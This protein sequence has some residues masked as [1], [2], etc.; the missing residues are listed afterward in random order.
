MIL[1][2]CLSLSIQALEATLKKYVKYKT[3]KAEEK[4]NFRFYNILSYTDIASP[5]K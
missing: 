3:G 4:Q 2:C 1:K 5:Y